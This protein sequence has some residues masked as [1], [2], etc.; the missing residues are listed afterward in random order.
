MVGS[1]ETKDWWLEKE[2]PRPDYYAMYTPRNN[3]MFF[4]GAK[5]GTSE[6]NL[7]IF[8]EDTGYTDEF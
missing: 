6:E 4:A 3:V 8:A 5:Y 1:Y 7:T 2:E